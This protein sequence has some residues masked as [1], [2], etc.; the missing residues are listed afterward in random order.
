M[1]E[2]IRAALAMRGA[3]MALGPGTRGGSRSGTAPTGLGPGTGWPRGV[4]ACALTN[5]AALPRQGDGVAFGAARREDAVFVGEFALWLASA[6]HAQDEIGFVVA[7][8]AQGRGYATQAAAVLLEIA[9]RG[10]GMHR[11]VGRLEARD[12]APARVLERLGHAPGGPFRGEPVAEGRVAERARV[13][14]PRARVAA[15]EGD[16][17]GRRGRRG[18]AR[19]ARHPHHGG[20]GMRYSELLQRIQTKAGLTDRGQAAALPRAVVTALEER[21]TPGLPRTSRRSCPRS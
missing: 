11:V 4:G 1:R 17:A 12:A 16:V 15:R 20:A 21:T 8:A 14:H 7:P 5:D 3:A 10:A 18:H 6:R 2:R 9:F 19:P 13:R